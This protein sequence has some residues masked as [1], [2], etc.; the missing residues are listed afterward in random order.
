MSD[1][2]AYIKQRYGVAF[3]FRDRVRH[4]INGKAGMVVR[5]DP[6]QAHYVMVRF[7]DRKYA[8]PC[9]P[10]ELEKIEQVAHG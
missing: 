8:V 7:D 4:T 10:G 9:H 5:E 2:Y 1:Q 6:S 3:A